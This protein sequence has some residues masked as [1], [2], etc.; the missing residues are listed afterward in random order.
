MTQ[1][2][3]KTDRTEQYVH[4]IDAEAIAEL[5]DA[6]DEELAEAKIGDDGSLWVRYERSDT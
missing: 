6:P 3:T 4:K 5:I 2:N 1:N